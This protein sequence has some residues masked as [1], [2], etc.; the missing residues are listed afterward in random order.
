MTGLLPLPEKINEF[1]IIQDLGKRAGGG[2][3][4]F[5]IAK[6]K[7]CG[8]H[9]SVCISDLPRQKSCGCRKSHP[10]TRYQTRLRR[11]LRGMKGRC[12]NKKDKDYKKYGER[13]IDICDSWLT[14]LNFIR[15]SLTN[16]Y[17]DNLSIDRIDNNKGYSPDNCRWATPNIQAQNTRKNT[18]T[19]ELVIDIRKDLEVMKGV[20]VAKKYQISKGQ[21]S[22]IKLR[23]IWNNI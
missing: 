1:K 15:W 2:R 13:G 8:N 5:C 17:K 9:F 19:P 23:K 12:Y 11:I 6:C 7:V 21:I 3:R 22:A 4:R 10:E 18:L 20:D 14:T 16:G